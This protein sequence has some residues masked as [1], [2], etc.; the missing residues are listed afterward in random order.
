M[1]AGANYVDVDGFDVHGLVSDGGSVSGFELYM[2]GQGSTV[3]NCHAHD[4]GRQDTNTTNGLVGVFIY[5]NNVTVSGCY[6]HDIGRTNYGQGDHGVYLNQGNNVVITG[7]Y[8][9][10]FNTGWGVQFYPSTEIGT[11]ISNNTFIGGKPTTAFTHVILGAGLTAVAF[12]NNIFWS[13]NASA[14]M[15]DYQG[16]FTGVTF[17]NNISTGSDGAT[18]PFAPPPVRC[19]P[20]S[21]AEKHPQTRTSRGLDRQSDHGHGSPGST[22]STAAPTLTVRRARQSIAANTVADPRFRRPRQRN[23]HLQAGSP[24]IDAGLIGYALTHDLDGAV[25]PAGQGP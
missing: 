13:A 25:R 3:S 12:T 10:T 19:H 22:H 20:G 23:L 5:Q 16:Q 2:G 6:M 24:A 14:T 11:V 1:G 9:D 21:P 17:S 7:N 8:F 18:P 4:I 15:S